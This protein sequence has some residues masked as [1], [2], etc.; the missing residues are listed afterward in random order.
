VGTVGVGRATVHRVG[1]HPVEGARVAGVADHRR[2]VQLLV[3]LQ[4]LVVDA[5][6]QV[7]CQLRDPR[8]RPG[9]G[10]VDAA[11]AGDHATG[12]LDLAV[13]PRPEQ[14]PAVDL[15]GDLRVT[16]RPGV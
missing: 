16:G 2:G 1:E 5:A 7:D 3:Q 14:R 11:V 10:E 13:R 12:E 9:P 4:P 8:H 6:V 15:H